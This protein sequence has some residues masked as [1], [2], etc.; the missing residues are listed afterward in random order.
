[1]VKAPVAA[2]VFDRYFHGVDRNDQLRGPGYGMATTFRA[3]KYTVKMFMGL[4]DIALSNAWIMWRTIH[5][6][7]VKE[8]RKFY[9]DVTEF[10]LNWNPLNEPEI[11]P[12]VAEEKAGTPGEHRVHKLAKQANGKR[13]ARE[14]AMCHLNDTRKRSSR[15]CKACGVALCKDGKCAEEWHKLSPNARKKVRKHPLPFGSP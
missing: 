7:D 4:L 9:T 11:R 15:G 6:K 10:L 12:P 2:K 13:M 5:P 14:C 3:S 1:M 8:H